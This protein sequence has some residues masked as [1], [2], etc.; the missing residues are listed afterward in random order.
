[1]VG[2]ESG[3]FSVQST[4]LPLSHETFPLGFAYGEGYSFQEPLKERFLL[5]TQTAFKLEL[6]YWL[7]KAVA[8]VKE[9]AVF[10]SLGKFLRG[11]STEP[12][13]LEPFLPQSLSAIFKSYI[14]LLKYENSLTIFIQSA[15]RANL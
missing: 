6:P 13:P 7:L 4:C 2:I 15:H 10:I 3:N 9:S 8:P 1:M 12:G 14:R 11:F 5:L